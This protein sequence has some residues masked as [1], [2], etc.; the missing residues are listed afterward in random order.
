VH[1]SGANRALNVKGAEFVGSHRGFD[2]IQ[3]AFIDREYIGNRCFQEY[4]KFIRVKEKPQAFITPFDEKFAMYVQINSS[5]SYIAA[6]AGSVRFNFMGCVVMNPFKVGIIP[7]AAI[8]AFYGVLRKRGRTIGTIC[9]GASIC[10]NRTIIKVAV[11]VKPVVVYLA[12]RTI[13][14]FPMQSSPAS[15]EGFPWIWIRL[16]SGQLL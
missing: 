16:L 11:V 9:H 2:G 4:F 13:R 5:Q 14:L 15:R 3:S 8:T 7:A 12:H 6:W 10:T 1:D